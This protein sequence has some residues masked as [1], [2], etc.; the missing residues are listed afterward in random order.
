[1]GGGGG[2]PFVLDGD[3]RASDDTVAKGVA[4]LLPPK[5]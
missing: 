5:G 1:M 3:K 4:V 2:H